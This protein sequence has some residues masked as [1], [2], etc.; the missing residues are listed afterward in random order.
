MFMKAAFE[1]CKD[2]SGADCTRAVPQPLGIASPNRQQLAPMPACAQSAGES[3]C[4]GMIGHRSRAHPPEA[5]SADAHRRDG[6]AK[7][8]P[9]Q[10]LGK[11]FRVRM[12]CKAAELH[13]PAPG[14]G[15]F[16]TRMR[17]R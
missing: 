12:A 6:G 15:D 9:V 1:E 11:M 4:G 7:A 17:R 10:A 14:R 8:L 5:A 2:A 16:D 3:L 13:H